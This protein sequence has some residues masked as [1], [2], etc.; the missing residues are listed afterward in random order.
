MPRKTRKQLVGTAENVE[1]AERERRYAALE[2]ELCC[3]LSIPHQSSLDCH[4]FVTETSE[5]LLSRERD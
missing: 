4:A 2:A 3:L 5:Y 1:R